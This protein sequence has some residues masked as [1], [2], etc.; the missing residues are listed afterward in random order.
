MGIC[1][2]A[3]AS[4]CTEET[5]SVQDASDV[6]G[7]TRPRVYAMIRAGQLRAQKVGRT[8]RVL[9]CDVME[10]FNHPAASGRPRKAAVEA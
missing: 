6:L 7:V 9:A 10:R 4:V 1:A 2:L 5:M 8:Y 3:D